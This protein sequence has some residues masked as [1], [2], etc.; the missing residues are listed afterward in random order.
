MNVEVKPSATAFKLKI[1]KDVDVPMRDGA[2]LKADVFRPDDGGKFPALLNLG[3]YQKD[4]LWIVPDNLEEKQN[5]Y[6]NWETVNPEWWVPRGYASVR[7][8]GRGSGKSP[9]QCEPW[10]FAEAVDFYDAIEWAAAQLQRQGRA[11]RHF[12]F[13]DQSMVRSQPAAA[14][15]EGD[16]S[17]GFLPTSIACALPRR[18]ADFM[19]NWYTAHLLHHTLGRASQTLPDGWQNNTLYFWLHNNLDSGAFRGAQAQWDK[20][21]IP[22]FSVGNW[23]GMGLHLRGNTEAFM[24]AATPHKKLRMHLG[25]HVHPFYTEDGRRDQIRFF[26][27]WLKDIDNGVMDEPPVKLAIRKGGDAFD[28][29]SENEWPLARTRWTKLYLDLS[30]P[31]AEKSEISGALEVKNPP[32]VGSRSYAASSLGSMGSTSAAAR[33]KSWAA[34]SGRAWGFRWRPQ[35]SRSTPRSPGRLPRSYGCRARARTWICSSRCATSMPTARMSWKP[36]SR[37]CRCRW[38]KAG[39]ACRIASSIRKSRCRTGRI[40]AT[41]G[42]FI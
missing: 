38:R 11:A 32:A 14:V 8:D 21:N 26:D 4:K 36:A 9:G 23:S 39:C 30:Q 20:I 28:W 33:R 19:T 2:R 6:M 7:V 35:N 24:H 42:G 10:S 22:M 5:E 34:A 15:T 37:A 16:H 12:I 27:H 3:P 40:T 1:D 41:S 17:R 31:V 18:A 13:R 29:R 25:S